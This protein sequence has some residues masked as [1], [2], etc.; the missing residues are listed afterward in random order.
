[1]TAA[2]W[3]EGRAFERSPEG[4]AALKV[5][6]DEAV[7]QRNGRHPL[8][9]IPVAVLMNVVLAALDVRD[10]AIF[11]AAFRSDVRL[12][13][14][15][16]TQFVPYTVKNMHTIDMRDFASLYQREGVYMQ[17]LHRWVHSVGLV[18]PKMDTYVT[19]MLRRTDADIRPAATAWCR[20]PAAAMAMYGHIRDWD[21]SAV[22]N[23]GWVGEDAKGLFQDEKDFD[24]D[25]S[26]WDVSNVTHMNSMFYGASSFDSNV[27]GWNVG[28][29]T[30]MGCMFYGALLFTADI[31]QWPLAKSTNAP[32]RCLDNNAKATVEDAIT[33][34]VAAGGGK[35]GDR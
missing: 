26:Q 2:A 17:D 33:G 10:L 22:T 23:M 30:N 18:C 32:E 6:N 20:D 12:K 27:E 29:V 13:H 15:W 31:S 34:G 5:A 19:S 16:W 24:E 28:N 25:L 21:T 8:E 11:V 14:Q 35:R 7:V 1:M 9:F 3:A 4:V